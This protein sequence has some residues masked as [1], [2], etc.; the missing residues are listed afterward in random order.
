MDSI[1]GPSVNDMVSLG[2]KARKKITKMKERQPRTALAKA[3]RLT[4]IVSWINCS[5]LSDG[6]DIK[7]ELGLS[8]DAMANKVEIPSIIIE[9]G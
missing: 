7:V 6:M 1:D 2:I 4:N 8:C 9:T 5:F 3:L